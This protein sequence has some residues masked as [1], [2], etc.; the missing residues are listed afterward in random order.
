M[1]DEMHRKDTDIA[2]VFVRLLRTSEKKNEEQRR[3]PHYIF[4][5]GCV[6][7]SALLCRHEIRKQGGNKANQ[8]D[9]SDAILWVCE[10][11][12]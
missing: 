1:R 7:K 3:V 4:Q 12:R 8:F 10:G 2:D 6:T 5:K 9:V 11:F